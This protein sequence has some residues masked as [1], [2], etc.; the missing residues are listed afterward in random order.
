MEGGKFK[1]TQK[2]AFEEYQLGEYITTANTSLITFADEDFSIH[3]IDQDDLVVI[4]TTIANK[5]RSADVFYWFTFLKLN[6]PLKMVKP[7]PNPLVGFVGE[8]GGFVDLL[9]TF[10]S[11]RTHRTLTMTYLLV[12]VDT[13]YNMLIGR[14][15]LNALGEIV[16]SLNMAM[17]FLLE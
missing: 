14:R 11:G 8:K 10:G 7:Y 15:T 4:S 12:E 2:K 3:D 6:I 5:G 17:K 13:Y 1:S 16:S 9:T